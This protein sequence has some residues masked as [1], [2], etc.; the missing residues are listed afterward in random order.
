[1]MAMPDV[2]NVPPSMLPIA[3]AVVAVLVT[4]FLVRLY[5]ARIFVRRLQQQGLVCRQTLISVTDHS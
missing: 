2:R 5:K 1:M 4:M 3:L